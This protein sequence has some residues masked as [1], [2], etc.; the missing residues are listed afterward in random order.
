[1]KSKTIPPGVGSWLLALSAM[2]QTTVTGVGQ[3]PGATVDRDVSWARLVPNLA[4]DQKK[5]WMSPP[6]MRER[7]YWLPVGAV[8]ATTA[9]LVALD[10]ATARYFRNTSSFSGFNRGFNGTRT[11]GGML[12]A[13]LSGHAAGLIR[14]DSKMK[15][16]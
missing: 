8:L 3:P 4:G 7:K 13:P 14:R 15:A 2:A 5:I 12:A 16:A 1:M 9:G 11:S 6:K 10:P